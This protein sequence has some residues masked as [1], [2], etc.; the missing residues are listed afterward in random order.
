MKNV[1]LIWFRKPPLLITM[2]C[3]IALNKID[4]SRTLFWSF[5]FSIEQA[6]VGLLSTEELTGHVQDL[7]SVL[8]K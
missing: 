5:S 1:R 7:V 2:M 8:L 6:L 3:C 4:Y